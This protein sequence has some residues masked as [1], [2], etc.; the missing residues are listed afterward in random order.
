M[1]TSDLAVRCMALCNSALPVAHFLVCSFVKTIVVCN[2]HYKTSSRQILG[3]RKALSH[4]PS[5]FPSLCHP[6]VYSDVLCIP[7]CLCQ[8]EQLASLFWTE[9]YDN[10]LYFTES[11]Q[12]KQNPTNICNNIKYS[13]GLNSTN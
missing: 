3:R 5:F 13:P 11:N 4:F 9:R 10:L 2:E 12:F 1:L 8:S 7:S 6:C